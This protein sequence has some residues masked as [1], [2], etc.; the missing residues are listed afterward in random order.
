MPLITDSEM[1]DFEAAIIDAGFEVH[2]FNAH[3]LEDEPTVIEQ[4][5]DETAIKQYV[6]TG[7][8][9]IQRIS[10]NDAITY[11]AGSDSIWPQ[12]FEADLQAGKFG[13]P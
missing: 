6:P 3:P 2:D 10:T 12:A 9:T 11:K 13:Q 4:L 8:V 7:T 1:E 5:E